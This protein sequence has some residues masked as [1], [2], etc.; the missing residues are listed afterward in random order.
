M[1]VC[2]HVYVYAYMHVLVH[3]PM[4]IHANVN[5]ATLSVSGVQSWKALHLAEYSVTL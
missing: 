1:C 4:Y 3:V 2:M 5:A